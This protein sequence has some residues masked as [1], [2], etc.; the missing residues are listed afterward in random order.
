MYRGFVPR[1]IFFAQFLE[2]IRKKI[3]FRRYFRALSGQQFR[4]L[5]YRELV[6]LYTWITQCMRCGKSGGVIFRPQGE[7]FRDKMRPD[8]RTKCASFPMRPHACT[9]GDTEERS[10]GGFASAARVQRVDWGN[11]KHGARGAPRSENRAACP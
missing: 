10:G 2:K 9:E 11:S 3:H 8:V 4:A 1:Y 5:S 7:I 6:I